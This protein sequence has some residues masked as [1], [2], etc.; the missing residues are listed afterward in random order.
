MVKK[1]ITTDYEVTAKELAK[2]IGADGEVC[3]CTGVYENSDAYNAGRTSAR[4]K[5]TAFKISIKIKTDI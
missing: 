3:M 1:V 2:L 4:G 5:L